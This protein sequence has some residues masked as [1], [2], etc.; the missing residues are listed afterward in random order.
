MYKA[1]AKCTCV[2]LKFAWLVILNDYSQSSY[3]TW[4]TFSPLPYFFFI[5][6]Y[7]AHTLNELSIKG[8]SGHFSAKLHNLLLSTVAVGNV[9]FVV[10][11]INFAEISNVNDL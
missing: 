11:L 10:V 6:F 3:C 9:V 2:Y 8:Q 5:P 4:F 1:I 7:A